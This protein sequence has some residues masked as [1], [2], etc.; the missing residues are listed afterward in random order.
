MDLLTQNNLH[1]SGPDLQISGLTQD[2][3]KVQPG[4]LFAAIPGT[5]AD[6]RGFI[7][8]AIARGA[9]A[10]LAERGTV[11]SVPVIESDNP[12][13]DLAMMA[14]QFYP[15]QPK[16]IAA[17]TG[18]N[19][20]TST[21]HFTQQLWQGAGLTSVSLGTIGLRGAINR[22]GS[23]TTPDPV[24]L[25]AGLAELAQAGIDHLAM[26][27][28]S[29]GLEQY[30]LDG[31]RIAAAGFTN[32]T[33]DHLDYHG[34][35]DDYLMAK[36]RLF[37]LLSADGIAV[38]NADAPEFEFL[39]QRCGARRVVSYGFKGKDLTFVSRTAVPEGQAVELEIFGA[40]HKLVL[41]LVGAYM[42]MN[43]LCAYGLAQTDDVAALSRL[44]GA[45]GRLQAVA[46][47]PKGAAVYVDYAHTPD[48]L[49][50]VLEALRPHTAGR[51]F[52]IFGCGGDRDPLKRPIM[53]RI[54]AQQA[55]VAIIADDNP[56]SEK[57]EAIRAAIR[58]GAGLKIKDI[59]DRREA[60]RYAIEQLNAGDVL[61]IAGKGH[62]QGQ[63]FA[64]H[65]DHFDDV[66]EASNAIKHLTQAP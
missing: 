61:V 1:N 46:G 50:R 4:F 39:K 37:E 51:L 35:M 63:T 25:H 65:T 6:G 30:R 45:P 52:C 64:D 53:G 38:L 44:Q 14:A 57:P 21:V 27:A 32:L 26:E 47:H 7:D 34:T 13:R 41:P 49:T 15:A 24:S 19:G 36:V 54:A 55:D 59:G 31:V 12:R 22:D 42:A 2:S 16:T 58:A 48:A 43:A 17:V 62:E 11:A 23:M 29:H 10:I 28:S 9:V 40:R 60:I 66:E 56:R 20:K 8:D 33:H 3:R 18:T 5:K